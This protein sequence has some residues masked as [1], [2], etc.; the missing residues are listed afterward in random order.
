M[1]VIGQ[2]LPWWAFVRYVLH[3]LLFTN[4]NIETVFAN[5]DNNV[6]LSDHQIKQSYGIV[7]EIFD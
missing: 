5:R 7:F 6:A 3:L 2:N 4:I 1:I